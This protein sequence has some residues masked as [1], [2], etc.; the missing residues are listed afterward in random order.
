[1]NLLF[2]SMKLLCGRFQISSFFKRELG[3]SYYNFCPVVF[4]LSGITLYSQVEFSQKKAEPRQ[5]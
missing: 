2:E 5:Y 4:P 1:M 3:R